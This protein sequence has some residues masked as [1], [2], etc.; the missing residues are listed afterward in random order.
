MWWIQC[1]D[2]FRA[3]VESQKK[4]KNFEDGAVRLRDDDYDSSSF[5]EDWWKTSLVQGQSSKRRSGG[6]R[7]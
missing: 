4:S 5:A 3:K 7:M 2:T 6:I 1:I